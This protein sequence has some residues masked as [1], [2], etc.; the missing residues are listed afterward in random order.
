MLIGFNNDVEYRGKVFHI[1][2]EDHG[3]NDPRIETQLFHSGA[4][5]DTKITSY[6]DI[7]EEY[8]GVEAEERIK[9]KMKASHKA[10]FRN[11]RKGKYDEMAGLEPVEET[12]EEAIPDE[13]EFTPSQDRVPAA[14]AQIEEDGEDAIQKFS[15]DQAKQHVDLSTLK[16]QLSSM[17]GEEGEEQESEVQDDAPATQ[18]TGPMSAP[19]A[20]SSPVAPA[21]PT[22]QK[23]DPSEALVGQALAK[24]TGLEAWNGCEEPTDDTSILEMVEAFVAA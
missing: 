24:H 16:S 4:I 7:L 6:E 5:L 8:D 15:K 18:V 23:T 10:L 20:S 2:T 17:D 9:A 13:E 19:P 21:E 14:A 11:L 1:Q 12:P 22:P 3:T